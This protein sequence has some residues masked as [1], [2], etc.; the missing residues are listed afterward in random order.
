VLQPAGVST[1]SPACG[2]RGYPLRIPHAGTIRVHQLDARHIWL[3]ATCSAAQ[4]RVVVGFCTSYN[5]D[6]LYLHIASAVQAQVT[7]NEVSAN[8][9][10]MLVTLHVQEA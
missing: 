6:C 1:E 3:C 10:T 5:N 4:G 7:S 2:V 9:H 8:C